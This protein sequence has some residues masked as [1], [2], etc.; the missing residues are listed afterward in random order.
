MAYPS[1]FLDLQNA[2]INKLRLDATND[3]SKV[4]DWINQVYAQVCVET[5]A[6]TTSGTITL[7]A[8]TATYSLAS[9]LPLCLRIKEMYVTPVGQ[10][11]WAPLNEI[12]LN[13]LLRMRQ[14]SGGTAT[15]NGSVTHYCLVGMDDLEVFPTPSAADTLTVYY[16]KLP[17]ALSANGDVPVLQEP[18]A[19]KVLEY[20]ALAE[21]A[22]FRSD[23]SEYEYRQL[24]ETWMG[25]FRSHL[26]RRH[27]N[28]PAHLEIVGAYGYVPHDP[29][30]DI[31]YT[32]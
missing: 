9:S 20:G 1:T 25:K 18:Y 12:P 8:G 26:T 5:E 3:L 24:F 29:S 27:G 10:A 15:A 17:T 32:S 2:V 16:V 11:Q 28:L 6:L 23:P 22:D 14:S 31:R 4:K 30:T 13:R 19:S 7:A 21:G